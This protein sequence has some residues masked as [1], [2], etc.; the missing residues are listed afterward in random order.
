MGSS[1]FPVGKKLGPMHLAP[2]EDQLELG[3][4]KDTLHDRG[5]FDLY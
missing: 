2:G 3:E 1:G 5:I 4:G